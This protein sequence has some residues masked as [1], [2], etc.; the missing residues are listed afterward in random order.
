[1]SQRVARG[2]E[3]VNGVRG[4]VCKAV[5]DTLL[6]GDM[7]RVLR[8]QVRFSGVVFPG[9]TI[10]TEMWDEGDRVLVAASTRERGEP[11]I[12]NAAVWVKR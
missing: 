3:A 5:V 2:I 6:D 11:V 12:S 10:V 4:V 9:E 8:Y 1:M 7:N